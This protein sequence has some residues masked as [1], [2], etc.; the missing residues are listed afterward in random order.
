[1]S[2]SSH[3]RA[4]SGSSEFK[5]TLHLVL[6]VTCRA[7]TSHIVSVDD[8]TRGISPQSPLQFLFSI[9]VLSCATRRYKKMRPNLQGSVTIFLV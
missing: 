4:I 7:L 5:Y 2:S 6:I 1:M 3:G 9:L 8:I